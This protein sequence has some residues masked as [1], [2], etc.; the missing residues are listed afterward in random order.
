[1]NELRK[2]TIKDGNLQKKKLNNNKN[3][4]NKFMKINELLHKFS[5]FYELPKTW[6]TVKWWMDK[7]INE[8]EIKQTNK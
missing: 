5:L 1:M 4:T 7:Y 6:R 8:M 3:D 2:W